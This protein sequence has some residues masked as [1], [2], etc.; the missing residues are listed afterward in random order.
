MLIHVKRIY[1]RLLMTV[2]AVLCLLYF[3]VWST[4]L[5]LIHDYCIYC[6]TQNNNLQEF[7]HEI[8]T[9]ESI[10][11]QRINPSKIEYIHK[12]L[13]VCDLHKGPNLLLVLVKSDVLNI[14]HRLSIRQTWGNI[15]NPHIKV[16]YLLGHN[17]IV[18]DMVDLENNIYKDVLQGD[19]VD[20]YDNNMNKTAMA[21]QY[22]VE[23]CFNTKFLFFV[24]D[25]FFINILKIK[26]Y[27]KTLNSPFNTKLFA[28]FI[29]KGGS[30]TEINLRS[31]TYLERN[32]RMI[33]IRP[34]Q[35]V[36]LFS[37]R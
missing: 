11:N 31:G 14:G 17:S 12:P 21:Y 36:E 29:I 24:D 35:L 7:H 28:G 33:F 6:S 37:C 15:S 25:D 3:T 34:I 23:N 22:A 10:S 13:N 27:L 4:T 8:D 1:R 26:M 9:N 32:I 2:S 5:T 16:V 20:I 18:Q 19:F 30:R